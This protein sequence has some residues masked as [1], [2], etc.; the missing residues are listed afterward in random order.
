[1]KYALLTVLITIICSVSA[2]S[3]AFK[4][5]DGL[6]YNENGKHFTGIIREYFSDSTIH[7]K[8]E[9]K[10]G[11]LD[12]TTIVFFD[13]GNIEENRSFK[14]GMMHGMWEKWNRQNI[15]IAEANY[16]GNL[17]DGKWYVWDDNGILR[18]DMTYSKGLKT[19]TWLMY[20]EKGKLKDRKVF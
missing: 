13:D 20:D 19:G 3:Q 1:M 12:G 15:K 16:T 17:K 8:I 2:F 9:I 14:Q 7:Y 10:N 6:Y 4:H 11:K 5:E 18:Y